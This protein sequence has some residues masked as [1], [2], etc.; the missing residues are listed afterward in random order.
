MHKQLCISI[1]R[2]VEMK[3]GGMERIIHRYIDQYIDISKEKYLEREIAS[4]RVESENR[5]MKQSERDYSHLHS[6]N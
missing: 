4:R 5:C 1:E 3:E 2:K 6:T